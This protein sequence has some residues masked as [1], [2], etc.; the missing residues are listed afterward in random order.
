MFHG[1]VFQ[2]VTAVHALGDMHVRGVVTVPTPPGALLDNALQLIGNWLITTQPF[3]T[4]ALPVG[5]RHVQVLRAARPLRAPPWTA[6]PG[7]GPSPTVS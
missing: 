2:G 4:V 1:P 3:R 5:L 6:R 7:S